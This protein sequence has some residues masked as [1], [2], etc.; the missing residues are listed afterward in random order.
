MQFSKA[1]TLR[2]VYSVVWR[3]DPLLFLLICCISLFVDLLY[4]S[5]PR[6][7]LTLS[8]PQREPNS[9]TFRSA[10]CLSL[11]CKASFK[12][13]ISTCVNTCP[14]PLYLDGCL[15]SLPCVLWNVFFYDTPCF[16]LYMCPLQSWNTYTVHKCTNPRI[17]ISVHSITHGMC[18]MKDL[19]YF[20][21]FLFTSYRTTGCFSCFYNVILPEIAKIFA[22]VRRT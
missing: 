15:V 11:I 21:C 5:L 13:T 17:H 9:F 3:S 16:S 8:L 4:F 10:H 6:F 20:F 2:R 12:P 14:G 22:A 18:G 1:Y 7:G 19:Y